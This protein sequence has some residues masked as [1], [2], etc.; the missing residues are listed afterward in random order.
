[1]A[2][3]IVLRRKQPGRSRPYRVPGY[4]W[5]PALFCLA[6]LGIVT[7]AAASQPLHVGLAFLLLLA[8]L[9]VYSY[10]RRAG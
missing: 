2:G 9:P 5:L 1:V 3:V 6:A 8:G 10:L 7:S 4:P